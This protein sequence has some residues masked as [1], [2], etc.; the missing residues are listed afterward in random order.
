MGQT[1][2]A[3]SAMNNARRNQYVVEHIT[4][5][6]LGLIQQQPFRDI[7]ISR[8]CEAAGVARASFYRNFDSKEAVILRHLKALLEDWAAHDQGKDNA[9]FVEAIFRH[10]WKHRELCILLYRQELAHLSLQSLKDFCGPKPD[11]P[12][13][14]A[15]TTAYLSYGLY[16]WIEE[17]F[18]R[19]MQE[20]PAEMS[21]LWA[22]AQKG[23][24]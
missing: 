12:N 1:A 11:Q 14:V 6:M 21:A 8:I 10:Y 2:S 19:G 22:R 23:M 15:Y 17:W 18:K 9:D 4:E 5:A 13:I 7:S 24:Q 16:G 20:S 3:V